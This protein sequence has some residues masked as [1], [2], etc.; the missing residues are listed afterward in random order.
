MQEGALM[1][2]SCTQR[3]LLN[4]TLVGCLL[5]LLIAGKGEAMRQEPIEV[6]KD[7]PPNAACANACD[8]KSER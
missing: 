8:A 5:Q 7:G 6:T 2:I 4:R 1:D 3:D